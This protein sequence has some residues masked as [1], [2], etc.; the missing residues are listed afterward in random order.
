MSA[1][2]D[3]STL[4]LGHADFDLARVDA[5]PLVSCPVR[6]CSAT[7]VNLVYGKQYDRD[8]EQKEQTMPWCAEHEIRLHAGTF[9]YWNGDD[10]RVDPRLRN[11]IVQKNLVAAVALKPGAKAEAH[12]LGYEMSEDALSW[13][14]FVSLAVAG[15]LKE[16]GEW[17]TGRSLSAEPEL[18]LWGQRIG[19][20]GSNP[21]TYEALRQV[22]A[23][24]ESGVARFG[25]E[26]DVMLV[27]RGEMVIC[28]EAKFGS[29]NPLAYEG[30]VKEGEKPTSR[31]ALLEKYLGAS[32]TARTKTAMRPA[33]MAPRL[34]SLLFRNV[35]FASEMAE[36]DWHVVNLVSRTQHQ[37]KKDSARSSYADPTE[38][39][40]S[41]LSPDSQACFTYRTWE[42]L[43]AALVKDTPELA[44][45]GLYMRGKSAHYRTAFNL[46]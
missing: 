27:V 3:C 42:E 28:I 26:P 4:P 34:H 13:N 11:F 35:V 25:T 37:G 44:E 2:A 23:A 6:D 15:K 38:D 45:L 43:Y 31:V 20:K 12:R 9:V 40:R 16:A 18:Y 39:V 8:G 17:L 41:Y 33:S 32:T 10:R 21:G 46:A 22:R 5:I 1:L 7:L 36:K 24:L 14:V 29:G 30:D 19:V